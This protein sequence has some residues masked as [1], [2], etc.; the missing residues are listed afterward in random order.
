MESANALADCP[1][2][3]GIRTVIM[4][5]CYVCFAELGE[6]AGDEIDDDPADVL[7]RRT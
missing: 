7:A 6:R 5:V 2:C 3:R 4:D 1:E